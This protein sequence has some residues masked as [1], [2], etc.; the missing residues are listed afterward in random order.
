MSTT[1]IIVIIAVFIFLIFFSKHIFH[2]KMML[3]TMPY[4][5]RLR[6]EIPEGYVVFS[7]RQFAIL[8][9]KK[10]PYNTNLDINVVSIHQHSSIEV[11]LHGFFQA[12]GVDF[13]EMKNLIDEKT[14]AW[15]IKYYITDAS[16]LRVYY[17]NFEDNCWVFVLLMTDN[18]TSQPGIDEANQ[19]INSIYLTR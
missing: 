15:K 5:E 8:L 9:N 11:Y 1:L 3:Q 4:Y 17:R 10:E 12:N 6:F 18:R 19:L 13:N 14:F 16:Y 2:T 7:K